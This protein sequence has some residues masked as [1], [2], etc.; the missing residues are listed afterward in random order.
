[1]TKG[2]PP[3]LLFHEVSDRLVDIGHSDDFV[4]ALKAAGATD[5]TYRR[6]TDGSG[7]AVFQTHRNAFQDDLVSFF[8]RTLQGKEVAKPAE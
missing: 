7:H 4:K 3:F 6:M 5:V 1:V 8:A 2:A